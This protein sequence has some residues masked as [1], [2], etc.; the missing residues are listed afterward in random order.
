[1][2]VV[3]N[4]PLSCTMTLAIFILLK[5]AIESNSWF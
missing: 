1:M 2:Y 5:T 4:L 3:L